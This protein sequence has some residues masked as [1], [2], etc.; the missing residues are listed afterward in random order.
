MGKRYDYG[1]GL[2]TTSSGRQY[3]FHSDSGGGSFLRINDTAKP[4]LAYLARNF[5]T[6]FARSLSRIGYWLRKEMRDA[7]ESGGPAGASWPGR[8][9]VQQLR[10]LD[11]KKKSRRS[12]LQ[13]GQFGRLIKAVG[14]KAD[15][16][17]LRVQI[18]WLSATAAPLAAKL[19]AGFE[20]PIS[21]K[22][23]AMFFAAGSALAKSGSIADPARP[24]VRPLFEQVEAEIPRRI[25]AF[26]IQYLDRAGGSAKAA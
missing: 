23:R 16:E 10:M 11:R 3:P 7:I 8:S 22:M 1:E 13:Y 21:E 9:N 4:W 12:L 14:Y 24:L 20:T 26:I 5:R 17:E 18:G 25:E 15:R 19:Q 2:V 6:E